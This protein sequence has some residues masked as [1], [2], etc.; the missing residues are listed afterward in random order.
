M[1]P[2]DVKKP[3][4]TCHEAQGYKLGDIRGG[5]SV[6]FPSS[7]VLGIIDR[8]KRDYLIIH[9][10]AFVL[11]GGIS[12]L[13]LTLIRRHVLA[14]ENAHIELLESEKM[15]SLGRMVAGFAHELNTPV[16]VALGAASQTIELVDEMKQLMTQDEVSE[17]AWRQRIDLLGETT[18]L[19]V[20]N[21][22]RAGRMVQSFKR[23]AVD[24]TS[25]AQR[26]YRLAEVIDDVLRNLSREFN[27][28]KIKTT[29]NCAA[30]LDL[31]GDVGA[32]EQVLTNLLTNARQH[33]FA[34]SD[35]R[36][37]TITARREHD[38]I[39]LEVSDDGAGMDAA[40]LQKIFEPFFTTRRNT[41]GSGLGLFLVYSLVSRKLGGTI[42]VDSQPGRGTRFVVRWA[43]IPAQG[44]R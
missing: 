21:L 2:L 26:D 34:D 37:I 14:L 12:G 44:L 22:K 5:I 24:Q 19:T 39:V 30:G 3:C 25:E 29:V 38:Q 28:A 8:H 35:R 4:L 17:E 32:V 27:V 11:L 43:Y 20:A 42:E 40:T 41:G 6:T 9:L 7:Y 16:G 31:H 15:A 23:T 1:A 10:I 13:A 33:A 36:S 18:Q